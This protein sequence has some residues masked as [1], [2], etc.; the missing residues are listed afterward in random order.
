LA[1]PDNTHFFTDPT[2]RFSQSE[3]GLENESLAA[4]FDMFVELYSTV[5]PI[6]LF[7]LVSA[8]QNCSLLTYLNF[9]EM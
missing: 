8:I 4:G 1:Q 3:Q 7:P 9:H 6:P 2:H 5:S